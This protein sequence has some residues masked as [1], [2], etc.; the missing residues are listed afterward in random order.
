MT[1]L[2]ITIPALIILFASLGLMRKLLDIL[3]ETKMRF[4]TV[5]FLMFVYSMMVATCLVM[6]MTKIGEMVR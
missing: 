4:T 6:T 3:V 1:V 5:V 2:F